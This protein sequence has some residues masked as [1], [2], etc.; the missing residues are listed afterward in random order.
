MHWK[1]RVNIT[2]L[3]IGI[4]AYACNAGTLDEPVPG[5]STEVIGGKANQSAP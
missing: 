1:K 3:M 5:A 4:G 2:F